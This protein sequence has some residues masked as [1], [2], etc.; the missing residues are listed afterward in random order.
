[1]STLLIKQWR[2]LASHS[3]QY[4]GK[5]RS[6]L[7]TRGSFLV[8][9]VLIWLQKIKSKCTTLFLVA[10]MLW[11][12]LIKLVVFQLSCSTIVFFC[13]CT[14]PASLKNHL[15]WLYYAYLAINYSAKKAIWP[16]KVFASLPLC[17]LNACFQLPWL[18][19]LLFALQY[20]TIWLPFF[21]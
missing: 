15:R 8:C 5:E 20:V 19:F 7:P 18:P 17:N 6:I 12:C 4:P 11:F 10:K 14:N 16:A 2:I 21:P 3:G 13:V 1:M 9:Y